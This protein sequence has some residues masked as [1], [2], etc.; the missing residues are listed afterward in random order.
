MKVKELIFTGQEIVSYEH[1]KTMV[2]C[3]VCGEKTG[4]N[5]DA[6]FDSYQDENLFPAGAYVHFKC[7]SKKRKD[8]ISGERPVAK[9]LLKEPS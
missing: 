1:G 4:T 5:A 2:D 6:Y 7:L 8:Q 3:P 9:N